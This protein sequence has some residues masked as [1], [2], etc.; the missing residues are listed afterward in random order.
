M[1]IGRQI[2]EHR[3]RVG[4]TQEKLAE[5]LNLSAQAISKWEN[6]STLP[7]ITLLPEISSIFGVTIDELFDCPEEMHLNRI[8][9]MLE[10]EPLL[11]RSDFDYAVSRLKEGLEKPDTRARCLGLLAELYQQ[12][13]AGYATLAADTAREAIAADPENSGPHKTL[14]H[15]E[16][17]GMGDWCYANHSRLIEFY[18]CFTRDHPACRL[19]YLWLMDNLIADHRLAEAR[20]ALTAMQTVADTY[21]VPLY[22]GWIAHAAGND[23]KAERCWQE[24]TNRFADNWLAWF[25]RADTYAHRAMYPEAIQFCLEAAKRQTPPRYTDVWDTI[26][27]L[28]LLTGNKAQAREAWQN[29]LTILREDWQLTEGETVRGYEENLAQLGEN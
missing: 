14:F 3:L 7:D 16:R 28:S 2:R 5:R 23:A 13:S 20:E 10:R 18:Q 1:N 27:Q 17:G 11:S 6:G 26:A 22:A 19:G 8:E 24:M 21:H 12:R 4:L 9:A 15:A 29:V 25:M